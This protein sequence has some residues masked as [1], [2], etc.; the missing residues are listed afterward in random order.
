MDPVLSLKR[1]LP[2]DYSVCIFCQ[3]HKPRDPVSKATDHGLT[4]VKNAAITRKKL[5]DTNNTDLINRLENV[6]DSAE[7]RTLVWHRIC[8]ARATS[9]IRAKSNGCRSLSQCRQR[10]PVAAAVVF[11]AMTSV[12]YA[13]VCNQSTGTFAFSVKLI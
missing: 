13:R 1:T 5:K 10:K 9:R 12:H 6:F 3:T 11:Y 2:V 8:Y 7:A 4:T